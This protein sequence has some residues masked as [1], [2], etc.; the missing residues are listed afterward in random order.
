MWYGLKT[1]CDVLSLLYKAIEYFFMNGDKFGE[2][3]T[4]VLILGL[5]LYG[6][7]MKNFLKK[8]EEL[9][10]KIISLNIFS[11]FLSVVSSLHIGLIG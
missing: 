9:V 3:E 6:T 10:L 5:V 11:A 1:I 4:F 7:K 2:L 8:V